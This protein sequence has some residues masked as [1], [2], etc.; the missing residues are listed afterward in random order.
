[1][2]LEIACFSLESALIA[3]ENLADRIE[4]CSDIKS[5]GLTPDYQMAKSSRT[6]ISCDLYMMIRPRSGDFVYTAKE[7]E[8]MKKDIQFF[9]KIEAD[10]FVFGILNKDGTVNISQNK[11]LVSLAAPLPCTFHRAFDS[12]P[13]PQKAL[14]D[15]I[16]CGFSTVLTSGQAKTALQGVELIS[17]LASIAKK[18]ITMMPGGGVRSNNIASIVQKVSTTYCHSS[19]IVNESNLPSIKEI[20]LLRKNMRE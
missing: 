16:S 18:K 12:T 4:L 10:G 19:A 8:Q 3:H 7:F 1:M 13:N 2:K 9:K 15:I 20:Q 17:K 11:R 6:K 5:G 14:A